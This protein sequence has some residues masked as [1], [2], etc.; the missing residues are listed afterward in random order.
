MYINSYGRL[1]SDDYL[2]HHGILGQKWGRRNGPPYPLGA[3][4]HSAAEKKA[5]WR[6]SLGKSVRYGSDTKT[7][8]KAKPRKEVDQT[9]ESST[10]SAKFFAA[11]VALDVVMLNPFALVVDSKRLIDYGR[12]KSQIAMEKKRVEKLSLDKKT[13]FHLKEG[14]S[15]P[16][17]DM[18]H[19]NPGYMNFDSNTKNNCM[20]CTTAYELRRRGYDVQAGTSTRGYPDNEVTKWFPKAKIENAYKIDTFSKAQVIKERAKA[21]YGIGGKKKYEQLSSAL[22]SHGDGARGN[23]MLQWSMGGG[24]SVV[25]ENQNGSF[26]IRDCQSNRVYSNKRQIQNILSATVS[27]NYARTDNIDFDLEK[28]KGILR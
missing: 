5:G 20:L 9:K 27:A 16:E 4:A 19:I 15:T 1:C 23:L 10:L 12:A 2:A 28:V 22:L 18:K 21:K 25:W 8:T 11:K 14:E 3:S 17:E 7:K 26:V 24:H 6:K 13:G